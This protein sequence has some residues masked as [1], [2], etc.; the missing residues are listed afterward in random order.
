IR[1][2]SHLITPSAEHLLWGGRARLHASIIRNINKHL[3]IRITS[4]STGTVHIIL[5]VI[6]VV[7]LL[8]LCD[9]SYRFRGK[10]ILQ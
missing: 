3:F 8:S 5:V 4:G 7:I 6:L 2:R 10:L 9:S 1:R